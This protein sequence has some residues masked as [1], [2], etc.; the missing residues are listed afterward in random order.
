MLQPSNSRLHF[1]YASLHI[2]PSPQW[3]VPPCWCALAEVPDKKVQNLL[4]HWHVF[5]FELGWGSFSWAETSRGR[6]V[7]GI[8]FF[9]TPDSQGI[10]NHTQVT[11]IIYNCIYCIQS[12]FLHFICTSW[13]LSSWFK[14][15]K[16][17]VN[18]SQCIL[19]NTVSVTAMLS[20]GVLE[21]W[22][23]LERYFS[24]QSSPLDRPVTFLSR[25]YCEVLPHRQDKSRRKPEEGRSDSSSPGNRHI[26]RLT[27]SK[28]S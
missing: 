11:F 20:L 8:S 18:A 1:V 28:F 6:V 2:F 27:L 17:F 14:S 21:A 3:Y 19:A 10:L 15:F 5:C 13:I 4:T 12:H 9:S 26:L 23:A 16:H 7:K 22:P 25:L 24:Y